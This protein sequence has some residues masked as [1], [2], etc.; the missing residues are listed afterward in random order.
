MSQARRNKRKNMRDAKTSAGRL[1]T[2]IESFENR[3]FLMISPATY[4]VAI[5]DIFWDLYATEER[6]HNLL[7]NLLFYCNIKNAY[8]GKPIDQEAVLTVSMKYE[9]DEVVPK[10]YYKNKTIA[11]IS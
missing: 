8:A 11:L 3:R 1:I 9:N 6:R 2:L 4:Q 7:D 10:F 5:L